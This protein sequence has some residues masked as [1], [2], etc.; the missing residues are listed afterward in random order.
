MIVRRKNKTEIIV[1][2]KIEYKEIE[3]KETKKKIRK[4]RKK[5]WAK[6]T[7]KPRYSGRRGRGSRKNWY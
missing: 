7:A 5:K 1:V 4:K 3:Y 6:W 2:E